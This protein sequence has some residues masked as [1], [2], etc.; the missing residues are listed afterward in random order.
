MT[1]FFGMPVMRF[2]R[3]LL[4]ALAGLTLLLAPA[5]AHAARQFVDAAGRTV[6]VPDKIGRVLAAGPPASVLLYVL[7][8]EKMVGWVRSPS[9]AEKE[10][11]AEPYRDLPETGRLTGRGNTA[12]IEMV[13]SMKPDIII[14]VGSVDATYASLAD[15]VQ[16]QTGIPYVLIDGAFART[17]ET[18]REVAGLLGVE[19]RGEEL[20]SYAGRT[21]GWQKETVADVPDD[22]RPRVYY[23][24]GPDGLETGAAGSINME[25]LDVVGARNVA[26]LAGS[27]G[28]SNV[29]IEQVLGWNPDV[30]LTLSP[31]FQKS[32]MSDPTWANLAAVK[33]GRVY[34]APTLPFGWFDSPPGVNRLMAVTWLTAILY[35]EKAG[36]DLR[37]RT[38]E[39][40][41][42]FYQ[43][44]LTDA[45]LDRLLA[46]SAAR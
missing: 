35:P 28:L 39:F 19:Q 26:A 6:E 1:P 14:D 31:D 30:I 10:F 38:R 29:S 15:R 13:L 20:A 22:K 34:R 40:Y 17:P 41:R 9:T 36:F 43:V 7:S 45:Q 32:V 27:G 16:E 46:D 3:F 21:I 8:P 5:I 12:N 33:E 25:I 44:D 11:L 23:G 42:L 18:L 2:F 4:V 24:R 37:E